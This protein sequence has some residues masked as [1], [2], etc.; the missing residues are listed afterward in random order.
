MQRKI[1]YTLFVLLM[2]AAL[3]ANAQYAKTPVSDKLPSGTSLT[4]IRKAKSLYIFSTS[5]LKLLSTSTVTQNKGMFL[6]AVDVKRLNI[7]SVLMLKEVMFIQP[8]RT[9]KEEMV[10]NGSDLS[11][12]AVLF[13]H[14]MFPTTTGAGLTVSVKEG[15]PDTADIDFR[16]RFKKTGLESP[17]LSAHATA[18][19]TLVGGAGNTYFNGKGAAYKA[20]LTSASFQNLLPEAD[21]IYKKFNISIQNHSYGTGVENFY[22]ADSYAYDVSINNNDSLLHMFSAGNSG[23]LTPTTGKYAGLTGFANLTGSFKQSKNSLAVAATDSF[24]NVEP[25]SS[26]GPAYDGR[27]KPELTAFGQD[28]SSGAAAL[29]SGSALLVQDAYKQIY[30]RLPSSALVRAALMNAADDILQP[31][32]DYRSGFGSLNTERAVRQINQGQFFTGTVNNGGVQQLTINIPAV[33][34]ELK[35]SLAWNDIAAMPN[36]SKALINDLDVELVQISTGAIFYPLVLSSF[37]HVDS[38]NA[39][40]VQRRDSLNTVEQIVLQF[41]S[42]GTYVIRIKGTVVQTPQA[43]YVVYNTEKTDDL[44]FTYP[45]KND[46]L[47]P[48]AVNTIRWQSFVT[49]SNG[50]LEISYDA[51]TTWETLG[52]NVSLSNKYSKAS[53]KDT[54]T[55][56]KLRMTF[57]A[58]AVTKSVVSD[59]FTIIPRLQTNVVFNCVD[60]FMFSWTKL[61]GVSTYQVYGLTDSF[62]RPLYQT[63]D[64]FITIHPNQLKYFAVAPVVMSKAGVR[65]FAFNY[66]TQGVGCYINNLTADV[67]GDSV[68]NLKV[69]L[70]SNSQV[71]QVIFQRLN[72]LTN[73]ATVVAKDTVTGT[74]KP[75]REGVIYYRAKLLLKN[76]AEVIS[77][78][79]QVVLYQQKQFYVYPN[80]YRNGGTLIIQSKDHNDCFLELFNSIGYRVFTYRLRSNNETIHL[81]YLNSGMYFYRFVQNN[82]RSASGKLIL[83]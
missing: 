29:V 27:I 70:G 31:G 77:D 69:I 74:D 41:P 13:S 83:Q 16:K 40:A 7:D 4:E 30:G 10:M 81:P 58:G 42:A 67:I 82:E 9:A 36:A 18:M 49:T 46:N 3:L 65:S 54:V 12:N 61:R 37:P 51:G 78:T 6:Y 39:A 15:R 62:M 57:S 28:G 59:T 33:I 21:S 11:L 66:S 5:P 56:A 71:Q 44:Y 47:F 63:T 38:L 1:T 20:T 80:P 45:K 25:L 64:T 75:N 8:V 55:T 24:Y 72:P 32:P 68:V 22:G 79:V 19:M 2:T 73:V 50:L 23:N 43:F 60:S 48:A 17:N 52:A 14:T 34:K 26:K 53:I 76:G 35:L